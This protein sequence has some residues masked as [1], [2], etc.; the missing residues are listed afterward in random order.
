MQ[1]GSPEALQSV[2]ADQKAMPRSKVE[3]DVEAGRA[4]TFKLADGTTTCAYSL[5]WMQTPY[6]CFSANVIESNATI[7]LATDT[8]AHRCVN[9]SKEAFAMKRRLATSPKGHLLWDPSDAKT[10]RRF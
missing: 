4:M 7:D 5:V 2:S 1:D 6:G 3:I 10:G 9:C 8:M